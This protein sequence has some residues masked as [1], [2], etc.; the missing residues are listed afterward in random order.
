MATPYYIAEGRV[1]LPPKDADVL[2]ICCDYCVVACGYKVYRWP[3]GR[4]GGPRAG[5]NALRVDFP[6]A[7]NTGKWV[8]PN[9]H[10][11]VMH[12]GR[13]HNVIVIP[14]ADS[15]VVNVGGTHS[16]RGGCIA[17]KCYNPQKP[18]A[19]RLQH[20]LLRVGGSLQMVSWG[21]ALDIMAEVSKHVI[22]NYGPHAWAMKMFSYQFFENTYALTKIA[23]RHIKTP[24][25]ASHWTG[26]ANT[27]STPG[28]RDVGF[29]NFGPAYE[30]FKNA[31]VLFCSGSDPFETKTVLFTAWILPGILEHGLKVIM[32][33]PRKTTGAAFS[34]QHGGLFLQVEPGSDTVLH[35]AISR[36]ILENGWEDRDWIAK[37]TSNKWETDSGFGQGTRNTPWQWRTTWGKLE[38]RSFEDY[39]KW[40]LA[41]KESTLDFAEKETGV[42]RQKIIK[43]A[44]MMAKPVN[45]K[46]PKT[47]I[48]IEKG[49][50][51]SN[52][53][54]NTVSIATL[55]LLCGTGNR[56]GQMI[57]R[58]G[59]H[60][61][62]GNTAGRYPN[63]RSPEKYPG[64]RKRKIDLDRWVQTGN[65]RFAWVIGT[66]W[67]QSM[68]AGAEL[69]KVFDA[70]TRRNPYQI[71]G[72]DT[73]RAIETLKKR[74]DSGGMVVVEQDI[75]LRDPIGSKYADIVLPA[76]TWGEEDF[77]RCNGERRLRLYQKFYDPPGDAK[78]DWWIAAQ[79]AKRMGFE[80]FDWKDSNEVFEEGARFRRGSRVNY[81]PLVWLAKKNGMRGHDL[82]Q[83][84]G[85]HGIQCPI[86]YE[87][88]NLVGTVRLHDSTLKLPETGPQGPTVW[89]KWLTAS[90]SQSGKFNWMR[91]PWDLFA[92]YYD[93]LKPRGDELWLSNVRINETWQTMFDD[94]RKPY[95]A[96]RW[97]EIF[98]EIHPDDARPR[99]I[100]SGDAVSLT[101]DR[102]PVQTGG[103]YG[104]MADDASFTGLMKNGHIKMT[105]A[106]ISAVA[107][108]TP[109]VKKGVVAALKFD[110]TN[111]VNDLIPRVTDPFNNHYRFMLAV[112]KVKKIGESPYKRSLNAMSFA[113]RDIV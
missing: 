6:V 8:S 84:Y 113:R 60:Q 97:P 36:V 70:M 80:G 2:T 1:P 79:F 5:E 62:G 105:R 100:E 75:Y 95:I 98:V 101:N 61:R 29:D 55:A 15:K 19:D 35:M 14:D 12:E 64:R 63:E 46:R 43:A 71:E 17:Q 38:G 104:V 109:A 16:I 27:N 42:P 48:G 72:F 102:I 82:L 53:Y 90:K 3:V 91:S 76:A 22:K 10:N 112:A 9:M 21:A 37:Y 87:D 54:L 86:R 41:Q 34:E 111:S 83:T 32:A 26:T 59:G 50:Y 20:P 49:N 103:F 44:E 93:W 52:N 7:V 110:M 96:Q 85:T 67:I 25:W 4:E 66:T 23:F 39:K 45:G 18:T 33:N 108:V 74:V 65:V 77:T 40:L 106:S 58:F 68:A 99:G 51:W 11:V 88:G 92:D 24:A 107:I 13:P 69:R 30:D 81:H 94:I 57:G 89:R 31:D 28:F 73:A 78:P 47:T 56:P